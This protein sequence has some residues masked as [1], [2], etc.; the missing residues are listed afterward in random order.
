M[1]LSQ[2]Q[3][4]RIEYECNLLR[5][6]AEQLYYIAPHLFHEGVTA[7]NTKIEELSEFEE[8]KEKAKEVLNSFNS[9]E[10]HSFY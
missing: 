7:A 3:Q 10:F 6:N 8:L 4:S 1:K 9:D 2:K 5:V